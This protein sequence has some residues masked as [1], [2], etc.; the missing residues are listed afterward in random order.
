[1]NKI[2][3]KPYALLLRRDELRR[4]L[5]YSMKLSEEGKP[6]DLFGVVLDM[7][8]MDKIDNPKIFMEYTFGETKA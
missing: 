2:K 3:T 5:P 6:T 7:K 1:M 8:A 4:I